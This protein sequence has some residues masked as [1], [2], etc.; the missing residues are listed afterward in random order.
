ML[1]YSRG[2]FGHDWLE[3]RLP[4]AADAGGAEMFGST[5][6]RRFRLWCGGFL[7]NHVPRPRRGPFCG[8]AAA[9]SVLLGTAALAIDLGMRTTAAQ[10]VRGDTT[11]SGGRFSGH[12]VLF[13]DD[14]N[15]FLN[16]SAPRLDHVSAAHH[17]RV[18][19]HGAAG[20][21]RPALDV[22]SASEGVRGCASASRTLAARGRPS[23]PQGS[24][25]CLVGRGV[26][27]MWGPVQSRTT[28]GLL[29]L[30]W[31]LCRSLTR[32]SSTRA[33]K[34]PSCCRE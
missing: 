8:P 20:D 27:A 3:Y 29:P 30:A 1:S 10:R 25:G 13:V 18:R 19:E 4:P 33:P 2:Q 14:G 16:G 26:R 15:I 11:V 21:D 12:D 22:R 28:C 7:G 17:T 23:R 6:R 24:A 5:A 9:R 32:R 34:A 31:P